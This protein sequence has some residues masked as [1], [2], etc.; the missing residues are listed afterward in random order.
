MNWLGGLQVWSE[1]C[2]TMALEPDIP[3]EWH[4]VKPKPG[5]AIVILGDAAVKFTN[6]VLSAGHHRVIP[7]PG[8]QGKWPR[9]S[10]VHFL[11]PEDDCV[12]QTLKGSGVPPLGEKTAAADEGMNGKQWI[13][14][15][16]NRLR[17][18]YID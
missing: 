4:W 3:G 14:Q 11:R 12:M 6:G 10:L 13:L 7:A 9:Y 15:Q 18:K 16:A 2:H 8:E 17:A 1:S 5:C